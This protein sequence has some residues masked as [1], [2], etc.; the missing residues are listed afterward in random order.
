VGELRDAINSQTG[1][2]AARMVTSTSAPIC[3]CRSINLEELSTYAAD[4]HAGNRRPGPGERAAHTSP[5]PERPPV[6]RAALYV[7]LVLPNRKNPNVT[8]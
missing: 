5:M 8:V 7:S 4:I 1:S 2:L 3:L 6:T